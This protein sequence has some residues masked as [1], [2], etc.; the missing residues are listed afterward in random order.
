[1][2][3][4]IIY[5]D[6]N[7]ELK[8]VVEGE[9]I[10]LNQKQL[11]ELFGRDKSVISL[12]INNVFKVMSLRN[13]QLLQKMQQFKKKVKTAFTSFYFSKMS[14]GSLGLMGLV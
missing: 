5:D 8:T 2:S 11:C 6:G 7:V 13:M 1:M 10:W 12:H 3:K 9:T 4:I 14:G